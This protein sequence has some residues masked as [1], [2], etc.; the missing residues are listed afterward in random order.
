MTQRK[1][2]FFPQDR[3]GDVIAA[4]RDLNDASV[5]ADLPKQPQRAIKTANAVE[6]Q[7]TPAGTKLVGNM[8]TGG[9]PQTPSRIPVKAS[10]DLAAGEF[11]GRA[12]R[13]PKVGL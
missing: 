6:F 9:D 2:S 1:D 12:A 3:S 8:E 11:S 5:A 10:G 13:T 4:N 7:P